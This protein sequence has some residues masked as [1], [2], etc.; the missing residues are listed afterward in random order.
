MITKDDEILIKKRLSGSF[1]LIDQLH[2]SKQYLELAETAYKN[3]PLQNEDLLNFHAY[4]STAVI[5]YAKLFASSGKG[6]ISLDKNK[7]FKN[8]V[9]LLS[10]HGEIMTL[11]HEFVAHNGENDAI[12]ENIRIKEINGEAVISIG[13]KLNLQITALTKLRVLI[14]YLGQTIGLKPGQ[15]MAQLSKK[16][17]YRVRQITNKDMQKC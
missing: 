3:H 8:E 12:F 14:E 1:F 7:E 15:R 11:R 16:L 2:K 10:I 5:E 13:A 6:K 9:G 4:L 17:G